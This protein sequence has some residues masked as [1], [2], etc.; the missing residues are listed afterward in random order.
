MTPLYLHSPTWR[1][2]LSNHCAKGNSRVYTLCT[3]RLNGPSEK[4]QPK[5]K[6][7]DLTDR[8][9]CNCTGA[10]VQFESRSFE[11]TQESKFNNFTHPIPSSGLGN[12]LFTSVA[13]NVT[14]STRRVVSHVKVSF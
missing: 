7:V 13:N 2:A 4:I 11:Q 5:S 14:C 10:I 8:R 1:F 12:F 3:G 9:V 6:N